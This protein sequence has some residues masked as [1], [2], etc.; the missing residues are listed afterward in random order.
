MSGRSDRDAN[1]S[2]VVF[3]LS[4]QTV[5]NAVLVFRR[6][7]DGSLTPQGTVASGGT[8][9]G[10]GLGS[11]NAVVLSRDGKLLFAVNAGSNSVSS[12]AVT[13][14]SL[15]LVSTA[16]SAGVQPISLTAAGGLLYVV[17]AGGAGN[18]AGSATTHAVC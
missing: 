17:N 9:T 15:T 2:G 1:A 5:G 12:F 14:T 7:A 4:N 16:P 6:A 10:G 13:G 11:Q 8:G 18:I 3:T